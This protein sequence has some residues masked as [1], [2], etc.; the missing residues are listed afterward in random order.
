[1]T[2]AIR[3]PRVWDDE[4][5]KRIVQQATE[6]FRNAIVLPSEYNIEWLTHPGGALEIIAHESLPQAVYT[7]TST[8]K[9]G[10]DIKYPHV[11]FK[12]KKD[13]YWVE[14]FYAN[15]RSS[16]RGWDFKTYK[17]LKRLWRSKVVEFYC[18]K[19]YPSFPDFSP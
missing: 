15:A 3:T 9:H 16:F 4:V 5:F 2:I 6:S 11:C 17:K 19:C 14:L 12:C 7:N 1:M 13:L 18:C 8:K 10:L